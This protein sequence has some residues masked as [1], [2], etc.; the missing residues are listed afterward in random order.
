M[1]NRWPRRDL[2]SHDVAP[3]HVLVMAAPADTLLRL[4]RVVP[5]GT[6]LC[7]PRPRCR[8]EAGHAGHRGSS[9]VPELHPSLS[10]LATRYMG[11]LGEEGASS[12]DSE[13]RTRRR[14]TRRR[15]RVVAR[16]GEEDA[17][18]LDSEKRARRRSTRRRGRVVA[19]LGEEGASS[20]DSEKRARRRSA[21]SPSGILA[22]VAV[23]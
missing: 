6:A 22:V 20:L 8:P 14:S 10:S 18:S 16:L 4:I 23:G 1:N 11:R 13:K 19:R 9:G 12:L 21:S 5:G 3:D 2:F 7:G 17:S 15:G